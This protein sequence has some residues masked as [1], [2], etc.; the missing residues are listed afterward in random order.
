MPR[1]KTGKPG[2]RLITLHN[3]ETAKYVRQTDDNFGPKCTEEFMIERAETMW[4]ICK[5]LMVVLM[6]FRDDAWREV[7]AWS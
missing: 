1:M 4:K 5:P 3:A 2:W 6:Q 7:K